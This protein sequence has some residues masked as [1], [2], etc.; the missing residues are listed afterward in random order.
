MRPGEAGGNLYST[1]LYSGLLNALGASLPPRAMDTPVFLPLSEFQT[2]YEQE[3]RSGERN[4]R[5]WRMS[6]SAFSGS[7]SR[8]KQ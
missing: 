8:V 2:I 7:S 1:F 3:S 4:K 6:F 5:T